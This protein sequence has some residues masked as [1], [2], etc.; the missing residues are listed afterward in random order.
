L[1]SV[2]SV[3]LLDIQL[4]V[5]SRDQ[6]ESAM[7]MVA[8]LTLQLNQEVNG[9]NAELLLARKHDD[10]IKELRQ[11]LTR[12]EEALVGWGKKHRKEFGE[13]K[14]VALRQGDIE[15]R[16]LPRSV[17]LLKGWTEDLVLAALRKVKTLKVYIRSKE[18]LNRQLI[19]Q[20]SKPE[21]SR[22]DGNLL[23][24]FGVEITRGESW[25]ITPKLEPVPVSPT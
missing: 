7:A 11:R 8:A 17:Q 12:Y 13:L 21:V 18:S 9:Q 6:A 16:E 1:V 19:L 20:D 4:L 15:V 23:A 25:S 5:L 2:N 14:T 3:A 24:S 10:K 22:L